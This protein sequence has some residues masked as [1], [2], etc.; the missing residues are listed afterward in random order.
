MPTVT[1]VLAVHKVLR[2]AQ[3]MVVVSGVEMLMTVATFNSTSVSV[4]ALILYVLLIL[5]LLSVLIILLAI[6]YS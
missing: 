6:P 1:V 4:L 3:L 5:V 2:L